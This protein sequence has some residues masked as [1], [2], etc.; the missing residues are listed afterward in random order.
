MKDKG[1]V[2]GGVILVGS[3]IALGVYL[4][5]RPPTEYGTFYGNIASAGAPIAGKLV[6]I[7]TYHSGVPSDENGYFEVDVPPGTYSTLSVEGFYPYA[8]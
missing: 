8:L 4:S 6:H 5:G 1:K 7:D 2:I 3:L